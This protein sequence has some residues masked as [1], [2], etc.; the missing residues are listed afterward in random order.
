MYAQIRQLPIEP[1]LTDK[2]VVD[3][4]MGDQNVTSLTKDGIYFGATI[5]VYFSFIVCVW[6]FKL[7]KHI[8][9]QTLSLTAWVRVRVGAKTFMWGG[10]PADLRCVIGGSTHTCEYLCVWGLPPP[11]KAGSRHLTL[12][13]SVRLKTQKPKKQNR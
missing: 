1:L 11:V 13:V 9:Y 12:K 2:S 3:V 10:L 5:F 7:F 6:I 8:H 4:A